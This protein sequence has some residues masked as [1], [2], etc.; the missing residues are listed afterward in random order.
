MDILELLYQRMWQLNGRIIEI[1]NYVK[2]D[3]KVASKRD[4]TLSDIPNIK[5]KADECSVAIKAIEKFRR[6]GRKNHTSLA[7]AII[8][9]AENDMLNSD[10]NPERSVATEGDSSTGD[11]NL[12]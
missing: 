12:K 6:D 2:R 3:G 8:G 10:P 5:R 9:V 4:F 11:D 7:D 1:Q